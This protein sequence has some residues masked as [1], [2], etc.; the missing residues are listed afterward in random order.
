VRIN[1]KS[2][3]MLQPEFSSLFKGASSA[4]Q[5]VGV[6]RN[7]I[8]HKIGIKLFAAHYYVGYENRLSNKIVSQAVLVK[9]VE[10]PNYLPPIPPTPSDDTPDCDDQ[11]EYKLTLTAQP[12][13][14]NKIG[15]VVLPY[16]L[17][18]Y[19]SVK[20]RSIIDPGE[21]SD[22]Y[23]AAYVK[24]TMTLMS[25]RKS[26]FIPW[27]QI[28]HLKSARIHFSY[29]KNVED[30]Y[31]NTEM[32]CFLSDS[33]TDRVCSGQLFYEPNWINLKNAAFFS[34]NQ[35]PINTLFSDLFP[36]GMP[37]G[38]IVS[39][40]SDFNLKSFYTESQIINSIKRN[41]LDVVFADDTF[42]KPGA[43]IEIIFK[44]K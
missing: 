9:L 34:V 16:Y 8:S 7:A 26:N 28:S 21:Y 39:G 6:I 41:T 18:S 30:N 36:V 43:Q 38:S 17:N 5:S 35:Y 11:N 13:D 40:V 14:M 29:T 37:K 10:N 22:Y 3:Y 44:C 31:N 33:P 27:S 42:V 1:S 25:F 19:P 20:V 24:D 2:Y 4:D 12:F 23:N 15:M 32:M